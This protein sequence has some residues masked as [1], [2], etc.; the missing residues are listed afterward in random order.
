MPLLKRGFVHDHPVITGVLWATLFVPL[1]MLIRWSAGEPITGIG[2]IG[3]L[4]GIAV[5][6]G[7]LWALAMKYLVTPKH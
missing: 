4:I 3:G 1:F 5:V 7:L 2:P 6:G